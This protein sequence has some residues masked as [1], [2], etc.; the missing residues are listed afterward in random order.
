MM[1]KNSRL[2]VW[3]IC[4]PHRLLRRPRNSET[5]RFGWKDCHPSAKAD[6]HRSLVHSRIWPLPVSPDSTENLGVDLVKPTRE[7]LSLPVHLIMPVVLG[8]LLGHA[9][10]PS[11]LPPLVLGLEPELVPASPAAWKPSLLVPLAESVSLQ[12]V[13]VFVLT[14]YRGCVYC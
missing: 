1:R 2:G 13:P 14:H 7:D 8:G 3:C 11:T 9:R 5:G 6:P 4:A 10:G 12:W